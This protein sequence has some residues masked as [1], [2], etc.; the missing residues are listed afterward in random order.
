LVHFRQTGN[1]GLIIGRFTHTFLV[2]QLMVKNK[3]NNYVFARYV[4]WAYKV[5][6][7]QDFDYQNF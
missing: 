4:G 2:V 3:L 1:T 5:L 6:K 7:R